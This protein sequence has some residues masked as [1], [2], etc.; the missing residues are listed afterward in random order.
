MKNWNT[1]KADINLIQPKH[2]T[3]GRSGHKIKFVVLHHH[4]GN[5]SPQQVYNVWLTR[6]SSAHYSV[7]STGVISQHVWD[8]DYA[9]A[10]GSYLAN[11]Q[12]IAIEHANNKFA[13]HWTIGDKTLE[14]GAHLTAAVC[15]YYKLGRPQWMK[16]VYPHKHF[17]STQCPGAIAGSQ[18]AKYMER[19][20]YWYDVMAGSKP[21]VTKTIAKTAAKTTDTVKN[22]ATKITQPNI[23]QMALDVI[24][25][26][27]GTGEARKKALGKNYASVQALV[28]KILA[29][30]KPASASAPTETYNARINR[31]ANEVIK[32]KH[33]TGE[34]RKRK[35]GA[36]YK[37]V[38]ALVNKKL[39]Y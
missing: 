39:G 26:K 12:G 8:R 37:A 18:N 15:H 2:F 7:S 23:Q 35:L 27:Y 11:A 29:D 32:G 22:V 28:N 10:S 5:L 24:A 17:A 36:D 21:T 31:L 4:A 3:K 16:N 20:Q 13:P 38:Q 33:G 25:G 6:T 14:E 1:L 19:A 30:G 9:W 34:A